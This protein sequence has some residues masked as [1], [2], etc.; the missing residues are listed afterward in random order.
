MI[1]TGQTMNQINELTLIF[2][3]LAISQSISSKTIKIMRI[4]EIP[5]DK[6]IV[7]KEKIQ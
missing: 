3:K 4:K 7:K 2:L 5:Y 1:K 6:I